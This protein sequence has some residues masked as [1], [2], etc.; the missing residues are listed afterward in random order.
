MLLGMLTDASSLCCVTFHS[1]DKSKSPGSGALL[2]LLNSP[3]IVTCFTITCITHAWCPHIKIHPGQE[4]WRLPWRLRG[5]ARL[6]FF[7]ASGERS[8]FL[9]LPRLPFPDPGAVTFEWIKAAATLPPNPLPGQDFY[10]KARRTLAS[11][12]PYIQQQCEHQLLHRPSPHLSIWSLSLAYISETLCS[13]SG[14]GLH[15]ENQVM[16]SSHAQLNDK[17]SLHC[18]TSQK[19]LLE[20]HLVSNLLLNALRLP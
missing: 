2:S 3:N 17:V 5:S 6:M 12:R 19:L 9:L 1:I 14:S 7:L 13:Q 8:H 18:K 10:Q 20:C 15:L 16:L 11:W 4:F